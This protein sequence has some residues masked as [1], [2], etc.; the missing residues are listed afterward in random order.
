MWPSHGFGPAI[1]L[2]NTA[3][4]ASGYALAECVNTFIESHPRYRKQ[5]GAF[6]HVPVSVTVQVEGLRGP[7]QFHRTAYL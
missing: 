7:V 5:P 4:D 6:R 1:V 3:E 2:A